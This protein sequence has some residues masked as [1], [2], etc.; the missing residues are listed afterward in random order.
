MGFDILTGDFLVFVRG[1]ED[2]L[3]TDSQKMRQITRLKH[4]HGEQGWVEVCFNYL[5]L[6]TME[7]ITVKVSVQ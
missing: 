6:L 1:P 3:V 5:I 7:K 4:Q 2:D